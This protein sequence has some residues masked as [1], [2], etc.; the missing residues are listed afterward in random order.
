MQDGLRRSLVFKPLRPFILLNGKNKTNNSDL[1]GIKTQILELIWNK[2]PLMVEDDYIQGNNTA[3]AAPA[4]A[5]TA[6]ETHARRLRLQALGTACRDNQID[7][8]LMGHHQD[9]NVET[10]L[11]RLC[12]RARTAAGLAGIPRVTRIPEC[13][14]IYGVSESGSSFPIMNVEDIQGKKEKNK[15]KKSKNDDIKTTTASSSSSVSVAAGGI[16]ICRPLLSFPKSSLLATCHTNQ[17]PFVSDPTNFDPSLTPRNAIR[18]LLSTPDKLP[19]ALQTPSILTLIKT[20]QDQIREAMRMSSRLIRECKLLQLNLDSGT[21]TVQ[22]PRLDEKSRQ[23]S[24]YIQSIA[25]RRITN[26][27]SPLSDNY[28]PLKSFESFTHRIFQMDPPPPSSSVS[29]SR[30]DVVVDD[31][32]SGLERANEQQR[33][34]TVQGVMFN[35][36]TSNHNYKNNNN[37]NNNTWFLSRQPFM[38]H[39]L[40]ILRFN[41]EIPP[42][43]T[44]STPAS[45]TT[46]TTTTTTPWKL[47]DNRYWFRISI[48]LEHDHIATTTTASSQHHKHKTVIPFLIRPFQQSDLNTVYSCLDDASS[49]LKRL[50]LHRARGP[51]RFTLPLITAELDP[52]SSYSTSNDSGFRQEVPLAL[53]TVPV[54][55]PCSSPSLI[56]VRLE[57][58]WMYKMVDKEVLELMTDSDD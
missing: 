6:F 9:D 16:L 18:S 10:T 24:R 32:D 5:P 13:N 31:D 30:C 55:L 57:W 35:P 27:I 22:F 50:L 29:S 51:V 43:P 45:T 26:L 37:K 39:R 8:L 2:F 3:A 11:W 20:S 4:P 47:W 46:T 41:V 1:K 54:R 14:G 52:S 15:N 49:H 34:F 58:E 48:I 56:P 40:P 21:M 28:F 44:S 53:P 38:R 17:I 36:V 23:F 19:R 7:T 42:I 33:A 25:L 12:T